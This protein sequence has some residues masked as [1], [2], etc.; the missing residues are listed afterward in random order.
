MSNDQHS[1]ATQPMKDDLAPGHRWS[2]IIKRPNLEEFSAAFTTDVALDASVLPRTIRGAPDL[3]AFFDATR[4]MY[5]TIAFSR[6][7]NS[8]SRTYL[9]W[10]GMFG[11]GRVAGATILFKDAAGLIEGIRL[12]HSP[13][14][15]VNEFSAELLRRLAGKMMA[16]VLW[17]S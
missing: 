1:S 5:E 17:R 6:E 7:E 10:E 9:E 11:G 13:L 3:R 16:D 4:G 14:F 2:E 15:M 8:A 12:Y